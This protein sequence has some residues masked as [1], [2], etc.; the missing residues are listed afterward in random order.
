MIKFRKNFVKFRKVLVNF[1]KFLFKF[2]KSS[3]NIFSWIFVITWFIY[4]W[5]QLNNKNSAGRSKGSEE[6]K[7]ENKNKDWEDLMDEFEKNAKAKKK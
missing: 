2:L 6:F 3:A 4:Q 5:L 7:T 1:G